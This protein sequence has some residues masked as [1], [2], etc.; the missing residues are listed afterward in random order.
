MF[1]AAATPSENR[2]FGEAAGLRSRN[3]QNWA[4]ATGVSLAQI[5]LDDVSGLGRG[6]ARSS[7]AGAALK[8]LVD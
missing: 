2:K 3:M 7:L 8:P 4:R 5:D 1:Y 6:Q